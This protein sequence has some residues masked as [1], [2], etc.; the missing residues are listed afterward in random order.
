MFIAIVVLATVGLRHRSSV[1]SAAQTA[2]AGV[3]P[4]VSELAVLRRQHTT[5]DLDSPQIR[6]FLKSDGGVH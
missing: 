6:Q 4:L 2:P 1:G 5:A 3:E